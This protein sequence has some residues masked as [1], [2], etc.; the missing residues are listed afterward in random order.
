MSR[1]SPV[2]R[3]ILQPNGALLVTGRIFHAALVRRG[4]GL[5][6][7]ALRERRGRSERPVPVASAGETGCTAGTSTSTSTKRG[8]RRELCGTLQEPRRSGARYCTTRDPARIRYRRPRLRDSSRWERDHQTISGDHR[9]PR[10]AGSLRRIS[11]TTPPRTLWIA[12]AA[13]SWRPPRSARACQ[14]AA[15]WSWPRLCQCQ[16]DV[17]LALGGRR[18][19]VLN[20]G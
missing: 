5:F 10:C 11:S 19:L 13:H 1:S 16:P 2:R 9:Y 8:D 6:G 15:R 7:L 20:D 18:R 14:A 3:E 12:Q 4:S 17:T